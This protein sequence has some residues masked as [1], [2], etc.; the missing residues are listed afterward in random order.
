MFTIL[1]FSDH[2]GHSL[3]A[4]KDWWFDTFSTLLNEKSLIQFVPHFPFK[5]NRDTTTRCQFHKHFTRSFC[6]VIF[7]CQKNTNLKSKYKNFLRKTQN[8]RTKKPRVKCWWNWPKG[9]DD[10]LFL[11]KSFQ[12]FDLISFSWTDLMLIFSLQKVSPSNF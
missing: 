1:S 9:D 3:W 2:I 8:F 5:F 6:A 4:T 12:T 11:S 10:G 7:F